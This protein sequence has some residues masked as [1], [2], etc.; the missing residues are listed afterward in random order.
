M[1]KMQVL[2]VDDDAHVRSFLSELLESN[3]YSVIE[4]ENGRAAQESCQYRT[5]D[6]VITD[7]V[8]PEQDGL[9]TIHALHQ[10]WPGMPVIAIS[11]AFGGAYLGM[12]RKFGASA[13]FQKPLFPEQILSE[14]HRLTDTKV[15]EA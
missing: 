1:E 7:L 13:T 5:P 12:A 4:A 10:D 9:A 8:M 3:G 2:V 14:V 6:L 15:S 11:G